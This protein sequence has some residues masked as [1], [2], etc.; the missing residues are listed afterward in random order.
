MDDLLGIT[1]RSVA[2]S[3]SAVFLATLWSIP[4]SITMS[5]RK[6]RISTVIISFF[7]SLIGIPT[8]L[9]GLVLIMLL[10]S[11]GP[12]GFLKLLYTPYAIIIGQAL[13]ITPWLISLSYEV[14]SNARNTYWE[15]AISMGADN[16]TADLIMLRET[17]PEILI[18]LLLVFSRAIGELGIALIVGGDIEGYTRVL[19]TAIASA[20]SK[21]DL[22]LA[23]CLGGI[24]LLIL[25]S[26]SIM[27]RLLK[28]YK[29]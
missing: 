6:T 13:L 3:T 9:I 26:A 29:E 18:I 28:A 23:F 14:F 5:K 24:L 8:V 7:N 22:T 16:R 2:V 12:L 4:T 11:S 25:I 20:I 21:G 19:T 27:I 10:G 1:I 15:L 17:L